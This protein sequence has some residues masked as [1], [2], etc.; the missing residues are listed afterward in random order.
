M[1]SATVAFMYLASQCMGPA[2]LGDTRSMTP[3]SFSAKCVHS[4]YRHP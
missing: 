3:R 2:I 1:Q 4:T